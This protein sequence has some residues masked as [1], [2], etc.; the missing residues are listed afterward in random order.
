EELKAEEQKKSGGL[1]SCFERKEKYRLA[2]SDEEHSDLVP[3]WGST[4]EDLGMF[5]IG[6]YGA[7]LRF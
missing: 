2:T 5:G 6:M 1:F 3:I 4:V 7:P